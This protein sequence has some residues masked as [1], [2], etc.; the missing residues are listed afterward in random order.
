MACPGTRRNL[1]THSK[2]GTCIT[3][4]HT[5]G[6]SL[7]DALAAS[8]IAKRQLAHRA[9]A[10]RGVCARH[11]DDEQAVRPRGMRVDLHAARCSSLRPT[12]NLAERVLYRLSNS[13]GSDPAAQQK[14]MNVRHRLRSR[15]VIAY[16]KHG[17]C[18]RALLCVAAHVM[19]AHS[20]VLETGCHDVEDLLRRRHV[21]GRRN[22]TMAQQ[23]VDSRHH[24]CRSGGP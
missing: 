3:G 22:S 4:N 24:C 13:T 17:M 8:E 15:V 9:H 23:C 19:A 18:G 20:A 2:T 10:A 5:S 6:A 21:C 12:A 7:V 11:V 16:G 1:L 14:V